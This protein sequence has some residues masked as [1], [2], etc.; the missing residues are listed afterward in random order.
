MSVEQS[1]NTNITALGVAGLL[2]NLGCRY[3]PL[4]LSEECCDFLKHPLSRKIIMISSVFLITKNIK[5]SIMIVTIISL[6]FNVINMFSKKKKVE[7]KK[8]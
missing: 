7:E 4:E 6:L 3:L 5:L 2:S 8:L 1:I